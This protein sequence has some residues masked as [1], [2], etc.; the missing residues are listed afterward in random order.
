MR[1]PAFQACGWAAG[2]C[3]LV[4]LLASCESGSK[5]VGVYQAETQGAVKQEVIVLELRADGEGAWKAG[6][7][8]EVPLTWYIKLGHLRIH[9]KEGGVI[10]GKIKKD[11]IR[12]TLPGSKKLT[13]K[14]AG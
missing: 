14:K 1:R 2:L 8:A 12:M 7:G 11:T 6:S 10:V 3:I 4:M 5:Y 9:T 13:F